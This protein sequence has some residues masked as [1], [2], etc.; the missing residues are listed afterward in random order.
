MVSAERQPS[1][2]RSA[3]YTHHVPS[4]SV[5]SVT[6]EKCSFRTAPK[7]QHHTTATAGASRLSKC[8]HTQGDRVRGPR[9]SRFGSPVVAEALLERPVGTA[10]F[11]SSTTIL[12]IVEMENSGSQ[13]LSAACFVHWPFKSR[14]SSGRDRNSRFATS[15]LCFVRGRRFAFAP[16]RETALPFPAL[17]PVAALVITGGAE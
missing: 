14:D 3:T 8:H 2:R 15:N 16:F 5:G 13:F 4:A 9:T 10:E 11:A 1:S 6:Q 7:N 17:L 12:A